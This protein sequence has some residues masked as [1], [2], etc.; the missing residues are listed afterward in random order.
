MFCIVCAGRSNRNT[1]VRFD[2]RCR[3]TSILFFHHACRG[4]SSR[5]TQWIALHSHLLNVGFLND[6]LERCDFVGKTIP[7]NL[8]AFGPHQKTGLIEPFLHVR[9]GQHLHGF[10]LKPV[11]DFRWRFRRCQ[12]RGVRAEYEIWIAGLDHGRYTR[13]FGPTAFAGDGQTPQRAG[14]DMRRGRRQRR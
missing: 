1:H 4:V 10:S 2:R 3:T 13:H 7:S 12:Q 5:S 6:V 11:A 8:A 14:L 9:R